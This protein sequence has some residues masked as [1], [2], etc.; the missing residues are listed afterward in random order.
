[1]SE[2]CAGQP[3]TWACHATEAAKGSKIKQCS[4]VLGQP[5]AE[6]RGGSVHVSSCAHPTPYTLQPFTRQ[7]PTTPS[8][9]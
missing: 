2:Q 9:H 7:T 5:T 6:H 1:M 4:Y 3:C 8:T